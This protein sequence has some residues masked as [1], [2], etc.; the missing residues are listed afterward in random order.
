MEIITEDGTVST[1]YE[2]VFKFSLVHGP[3]VGIL[4]LI[5]PRDE[6]ITKIFFYDGQTHTAYGFAVGMIEDDAERYSR[7]VALFMVIQTIWGMDMTS[8]PEKYWALEGKKELDKSDEECKNLVYTFLAEDD[9]A[10]KY[11]LES[12]GLIGCL[13]SGNFLEDEKNIVRII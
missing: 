2:N 11:V 10:L 1:S 3:V 13:D 9:S 8:F 7:M 5:T 12:D 6:H 4:H